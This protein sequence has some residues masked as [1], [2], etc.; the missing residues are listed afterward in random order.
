MYSFMQLEPYQGMEQKH[1]PETQDPCGE[2]SSPPQDMFLQEGSGGV[3]HR[4]FCGDNSI[5]GGQFSL[6]GVVYA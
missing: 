4:T 2:R 5:N 3:M 1:F 6:Q